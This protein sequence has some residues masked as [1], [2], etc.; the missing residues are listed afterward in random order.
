M[1]LWINFDEIKKNLWKF[2]Q[3]FLLYYKKILK[4]SEEISGIFCRN[5]LSWFVGKFLRKFDADVK[6]GKSWRN[7][8]A[9]WKFCTKIM[10]RLKKFVRCLRKFWKILK[11]LRGTFM[12]ILIKRK[13]NWKILNKLKHL[14][15]SLSGNFWEIWDSICWN[16][17]EFFQNFKW[18]L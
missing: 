7:F 1:K 14:R 11:I 4:K 17:M 10:K 3:K 18:I 9:I 5:N 12:K 16:Y 13:V 6:F 8:R 2:L 15:E